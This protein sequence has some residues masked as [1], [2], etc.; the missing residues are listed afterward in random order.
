MVKSKVLKKTFT[1]STIVETEFQLG[2]Y[3]L[4]DKFLVLQHMSQMT[5]ET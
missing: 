2:K 5:I 1:N 4:G 3:I